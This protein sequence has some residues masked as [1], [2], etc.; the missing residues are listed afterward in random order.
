VKCEVFINAEGKPQIKT[1]GNLVTDDNGFKLF[2]R[3]DGDECVLQSNGEGLEQRRRGNANIV[4]IFSE[5]TQ[6]ECVIG[7]SG[8]SGSVP[9]YT[10]KIVRE[11]N[12]AGLK[13]KLYYCMGGEEFR[14]E[15]TALREKK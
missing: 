11:I 15:I 4:I 6:T 13:I 14:L 2:Y 7:E 5:N 1:V 10:K 9:V 12:G 3:L 8:L